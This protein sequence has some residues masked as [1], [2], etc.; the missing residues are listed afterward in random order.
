M[1]D[2]LSGLTSLESLADVGTALDDARSQLEDLA[3]TV[4]DT[5]SC[6]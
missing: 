4:T 1:Q 3:S 2:T 5:L 6:N